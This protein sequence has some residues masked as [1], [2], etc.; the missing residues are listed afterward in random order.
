ME[1]GRKK[2]KERIPIVIGR[3]RRRRR[4]SLCIILVF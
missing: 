2:D 4:W 1:I 3:K